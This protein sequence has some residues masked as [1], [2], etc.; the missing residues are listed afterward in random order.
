MTPQE[1]AERCAKEMG[2]KQEMFLIFDTNHK[3]VESQNPTGKWITK[4]KD[5]VIDGYTFRPDTDWASAGVW[6]EW[7][8]KHA[9][10]VIDEALSR[11]FEPNF[12]VAL[13][14]ASEQYFASR[15]KT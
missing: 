4:D 2:W 14:A 15:D 10:P 8:F 9:S 6:I 11:L 3:E 1:Y 7:L 13:Q 5:D 12:L